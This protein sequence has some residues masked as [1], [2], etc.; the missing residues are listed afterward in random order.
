MRKSLVERYK[1]CRVNWLLLKKRDRN[2]RERFGE[3]N[4]YVMLSVFFFFCLFVFG[5][6]IIDFG[7]VM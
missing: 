4:V 5:K 1:N 7:F 6:G 3:F 2:W